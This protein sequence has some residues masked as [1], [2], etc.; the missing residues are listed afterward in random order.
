MVTGPNQLWCMEF[1]GF[2]TRDGKRC[3]PFTI[4]DAY[5]RYLIRCQIVSRMDLIQVR[6]ICEAAMREHG[7]PARIRTDNGHRLRA[8]GHWVLETLA[9]LRRS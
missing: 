8:Q 4:S 2:T 9:R 3:D 1:K 6:A 5:S 7:M